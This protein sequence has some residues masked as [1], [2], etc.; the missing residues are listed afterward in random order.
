MIG[1]GYD[2][3]GLFGWGIVS[4]YIKI[5]YIKIKNYITLN[6]K[7]S[8]YINFI[9]LKDKAHFINDMYK[10]Y[11]SNNYDRDIKILEAKYKLLQVKNITNI[12]KFL[13]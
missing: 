4:R 9:R 12:V 1:W 10:D 5:N 3:W 11:G 7:T 13:D 2:K 8:K 6:I